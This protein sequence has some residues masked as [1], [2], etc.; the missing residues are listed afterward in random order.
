MVL[1]EPSAYL[2]GL[3]ANHWIIPGRIA[4]R[5]LEE[6][7]PD[8][9]LFQWLVVAFQPMVNH[10]RQKLLTPIAAPKKLTIQDRIQLA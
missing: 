4:G 1:F 8:R 7:C 6:F 5:A 9:A 2:S 10:I 3:D